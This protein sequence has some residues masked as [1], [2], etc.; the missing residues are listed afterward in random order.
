MDEKGIVRP[1]DARTGMQDQQGKEG[2][3]GNAITFH[4]DPHWPCKED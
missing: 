3:N 4:V 1:N 2:I